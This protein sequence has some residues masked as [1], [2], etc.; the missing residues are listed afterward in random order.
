SR[1]LL[2]GSLVGT[3]SEVEGVAAASAQIEGYGALVDEEG[4]QVGGNGP[5]TLAGNWVTDSELNAFRLVEGRAPDGDDEVVLNRTAADEADLEVGDR[6]VVQVPDPVEVEVVGI[7]AFGDG[8][9]TPITYVA[10]STPAAQQY[11]LGGDDKVTA[12]LL[13]ASDGTS[14]EELAERVADAAPSG[15]EVLTGTELTADDL[16]SIGSDF[17]DVFEGIL[18][19]FAAIALLVACFSI[20]NTFSILVAQR[21]RESAL[22]RA[23]GAGRG[24]ILASVIGE[25]AVTGL[26]ASAAGMAG[27]LGIAAGLKGLFDAIGL[28]LPT[29]GLTVEV[30]V[31]V[32]AFVVGTLVTL[33]AAVGPSVR[34][35]RVAPLAAL[36]EVAAERTRAGRPRAAL[37]LV[38]TGAGAAVVLSA[39]LGSGDSVLPRAGLGAVLAIAGFVVLGPVIAS[40]AAGL[41]GSPLPRLRGVAGLLARRNAMRNPRRTAGSA[42]A[43]MVGVS[44]VTLFTVMAASIKASIDESVARSFGG[45]LVVASSGFG[46]FGGFSPGLAADVG[47][48]DEVDAAAGLG[49]GAMR[50]DGDS[51]FATVAEPHRLDGVLDLDVTG[52]DLAGLGTGEFAAS[53]ERAEDE[54]WEV[55]DE[56]SVA[57]ADGARETLTVGAVY[58]ESDVVGGLFFPRDAYAPH[59]IQA[60]DFSVLVTLADG[61][62][63]DEGRQKVEEVAARYGAP[64]VNDRESYGEQVAGGVN[65]MLGLVYV[66]LALAIVIALMGIANTISLSVHERTRELGLLRALGQTRRQL[67]SMVRWES[68]VIATFGTVGGLGLGTFLGWALVLAA[69]GEGIST[70]SAP[71]AQLFTVLAVG[72]FAGIA[73]GFRPARRAARLN[74]LAAIATE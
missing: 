55:G 63:L 66:M 6:T 12:V 52:G 24:Q 36:R 33:V 73:A 35:S 40:P 68:V 67:R 30:S 7:A 56:V 21:T 20:Y 18:T 25:A 48:L 72:A 39:V 10:F 43:L 47:Q 8:A 51:Q 59:A 58:D 60:L 50:I 1:P 23:L 5:P 45:D 62:G 54:G 49:F 57:F 9:S 44:V 11:L 14:E 65:Q 16:E 70:F 71:P 2:D 42:A 53:T 74:I 28:S 38:T 64:D 32:T 13:R 17:L 61:V 69:S 22:L 41:I 34:A 15:A 27:G 19:A 3:L 37:G 46:P 29:G 26:V 4:K 31:V